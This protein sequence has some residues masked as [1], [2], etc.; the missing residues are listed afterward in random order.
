MSQLYILIGFLFFS[1]ISSGQNTSSDSVS[2]IGLGST[3][4]SSVMFYNNYLPFVKVN[5]DNVEYDFLFDTGAELCILSKDIAKSSLNK[6]DI[7]ASDMEGN[8]QD[9]KLYEIDLQLG[10]TSIEKIQCIELDLK[11]IFG[12]SCIEI[13]GVIGQNLIRKLNWQFETERGVV[14][15]SKVPFVMGSGGKQ[16]DLEYYGDLPLTKVSYD[17]L[18]FYVLLDTGFDGL[19]E[20]NSGGIKKSKKY[21][22]STKSC[23]VGKHQITISGAKTQKVTLATLDSVMLGTG[24]LTEVPTYISNSKPLLGSLLFQNHNVT[25]NFTEDKVLLSPS[26]KLPEKVQN[27]GV[28]L[29]LNENNKAEVVFIWKESEA[30][31]QGLRLGHII[32]KINDVDVSQ[33][34]QQDLCA[35]KAE[36]RKREILE[37]RFVYK[38]K[39]KFIAL[40]RASM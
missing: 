21:K 40:S 13:D 5:I 26:I 22:K 27:F 8:A 38:G 19:L 29:G 9:A 6:G 1:Y 2:I 32:S 20:L 37:L 18:S 16:L 17:N 14:F 12:A 23:G 10:S 3:D 33:I 31:K 30:F 7:V 24:Y 11:S 35:L 25:F 36:V 28:G 4:S 34:S 39:T 15:W